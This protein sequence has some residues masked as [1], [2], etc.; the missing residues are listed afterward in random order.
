MVSLVITTVWAVM[1]R[2]RALDKNRLHLNVSVISSSNG[3]RWKVKSATVLSRDLSGYRCER[4]MKFPIASVVCLCWPAS[5]TY[6]HVSWFYF[7]NPLM[8]HHWWF[9]EWYIV[10]SGLPRIKIRPMHILDVGKHCCTPQIISLCPF[11]SKNDKAFDVYLG[12]FVQF[13]RVVWCYNS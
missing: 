10:G 11:G 4:A 6:G 3:K 8:F 13:L 5:T 7:V 2:L 12:I 1:S 9:S